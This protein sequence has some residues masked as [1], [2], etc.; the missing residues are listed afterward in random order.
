M[1]ELE[2]LSHA[3]PF[4]QSLHSSL[5]SS[6]S[7]QNPLYISLLLNNPSAEEAKEE[8]VQL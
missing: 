5:R 4:P 6:Q 8:E 1:G 2:Y 7:A 3:D